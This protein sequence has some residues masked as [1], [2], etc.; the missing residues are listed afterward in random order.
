MR[1]CPVMLTVALLVG[2][3]P[4]GTTLN[5]P[6]TLTGAGFGTPPGVGWG[7]NFQVDIQ[8]QS[9]NV[10]AAYAATEGTVT[11]TTVCPDTSGGGGIPNGGVAGTLTNVK[12]SAVDG[13]LTGN[14]TI[15]PGGCTL[16]ATGRAMVRLHGANAEP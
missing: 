5:S 7:I 3:D 1:L 15:V 2:I 8:N 10:D 12:F 13:L 16:P 4:T 6:Y 11:F 9:F 14:P